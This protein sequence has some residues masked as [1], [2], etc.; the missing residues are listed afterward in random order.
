[1][2]VYRLTRTQFLPVTLEEAWSFFSN[3][4]NLGLITPPRLAFE[5]LDDSAGKPMHTGQLIYYRITIF[6]GVRVRWVTE[7]TQVQEHFQFVDIQRSGPY[8]LWQ[9]THNFK[10]VS[11]GVEMTDQLQYSIPLGLIGR[12]AHLLFVEKEIKAIFDYRYAELERRFIRHD[13]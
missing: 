9:H 8:A 12:L 5:I 2:K 13:S 4:N 6:P 1:M 7:I 10:E 11:G 3:P